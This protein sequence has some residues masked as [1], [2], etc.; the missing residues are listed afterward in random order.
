MKLGVFLSPKRVFSPY[1]ADPDETITIL[2]SSGTTGAPKAIPWN[3]TTPIKSASDGF[4]HHNIQAGDTIC[5]PTNLGWMMGPWLVFATLINK[6]T[7]AFTM[8]L[9]M[10]KLS[11]NLFKMLKLI[12]SALYPALLGHGKIRKTWKHL[13]GKKLNASAQPVNA[14]S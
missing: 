6:G 9:H 13:I 11:E 10:S 2:F 14:Q 7:I 8:A 12:C 5:W 1:S 3:H 4:Y